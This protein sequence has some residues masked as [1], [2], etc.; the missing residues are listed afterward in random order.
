MNQARKEA[1]AI[2]EKQADIDEVQDFFWFTRENTY[3][4]VIGKNKEGEQMAV[5]IPKTGK[6]IKVFPMKDGIDSAEAQKLVIATNPDLSVSSVR[7]GLYK[8]QPV[9]EVAGSQQDGKRNFYLISFKDGEEV[10]T[11]ENI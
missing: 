5:I 2:A 8:N 3:F 10:K 7:L 1:I 4:T 11:I 6:S 9:W